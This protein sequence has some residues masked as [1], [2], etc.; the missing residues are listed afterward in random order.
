MGTDRYAYLSRLRD[1]DPAPK[2]VLS[3]AI[4]LGAVVL[5]SA[6]AGL[7]TL[8]SAFLLNVFS[9]GQKPRVV[10]HFLK[11][12][13]VFLL[14]GA[15]TIVLRPL[16]QEAQAIWSGMLLGRWRWGITAE[17]L[18]LGLTVFCRA[19]GAVSAMYFL[20]L[21]TPMTDLATALRRLHVP[22]LFVE[23]MELIY[24]FIFLL[25][26]TARQIHIAQ[27]SR[28]GYE[29]FRRSMHSMGALVSMVFLRALRRGDRVFA[30]LESRGYTGS[31]DTLPKPYAPGRWLYALCPVL[32]AGQ[33]VIFYWERRWL[34]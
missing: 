25:S 15:L 32:L 2:I 7:F 14:I 16:P 30:A 9:G 19:M 1:V 34:S 6:A 33:A 5:P 8:L 23:L 10:G 27:D 22:K 18:R 17:Q 12:P 21:N 24:R 31:L 11:I 29:G 13:L 26:D 3:F 20:S 28:L 4:Q